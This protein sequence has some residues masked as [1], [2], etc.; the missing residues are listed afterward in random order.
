MPPPGARWLTEYR[1]AGG[2]IP[3]PGAGEN[4]GACSF[5]GH[6]RGTVVSLGRQDWGHQALA[7]FVSVA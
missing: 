4:H 1:A 2:Q 5:P 6:V 3:S 7:S